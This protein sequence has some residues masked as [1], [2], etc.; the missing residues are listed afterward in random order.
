MFPTDTVYGLGCDPYN[1]AALEKIYAIKKRPRRKGLPVLATRARIEEIAEIGGA[2]ARI[3]EKFW[4]GQVTLVV[5]LRDRR[6]AEALGSETVAVREPAGR[7]VRGL[8]DA[9]GPLAGTSANASGMP[10]PG[11]ARECRL[12]GHDLLV[13]GG[14]AGGAPSTIA[15][16]VGGRVL[17]RGAHAREVERML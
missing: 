5:E 14:P 16:C 17:R 9:C 15:D 6:L 2:A 3:A 13:D 8:L 4:P 10:A 11:S 12:S 7:C 1:P